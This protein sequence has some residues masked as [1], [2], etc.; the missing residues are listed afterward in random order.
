MLSEYELVWLANFIDRL[1]LLEYPRIA[2][3][4]KEV[5]DCVFRVIEYV[6]AIVKFEINKD[7]CELIQNAVFKND[8]SEFLNFRK[9]TSE[10]F[11]CK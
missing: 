8:K 2:N 9:I 11:K 1:K 3:E 6:A 4:S 10:R 7:L 5:L